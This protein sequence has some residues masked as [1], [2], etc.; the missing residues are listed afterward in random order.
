MDTVSSWVLSLVGVVII[1]A[2]VEIIMPEGNVGKYVKGILV[3]FT[4]F[5]MVSPITNISIGS[6]FLGDYQIT[7]D[8]DYLEG[9]NAEK[10]SYYISQIE[11]RLVVGGY[12]KVG[13]N[14]DW[15]NIDGELKINNIYVDLCNAVIKV[16]KSNI[17]IYNNIKD[18]IIG[19][20]DIDKEDIVF[21]G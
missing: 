4:I 13:V 18:I 2:L 9:V 11:E 19:V 16:D 14:V 5:V 15:E 6:L 10:V 3:L 7:L 1:T 12:E 20:V 17:D 8:G 21:N